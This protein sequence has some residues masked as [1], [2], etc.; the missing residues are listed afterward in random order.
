MSPAERKEASKAVSKEFSRH[1]FT[2]Q[3]SL[4]RSGPTTCDGPDI[5]VHQKCVRKSAG[6]GAL[7]LKVHIFVDL[8]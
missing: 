4:V 3:D 6:F 7:F 2:L 1:K 5:K 8:H